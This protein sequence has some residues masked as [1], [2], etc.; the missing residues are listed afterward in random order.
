[1]APH[2]LQQL[3]EALTLAAASGPAA[4]IRAAGPDAPD[5]ASYEPANQLHVPDVS[6]QAGAVSSSPVE[7]HNS[8]QGVKEAARPAVPATSTQAE[9]VTSSPVKHPSSPQSFK[10]G[11]SPVSLMKGTSP[12]GAPTAGTADTTAEARATITD[13]AAAEAILGVPALADASLDS[14]QEEAGHAAEAHA[15]G[16]LQGRDNAITAAANSEAGPKASTE[17]KVAPNSSANVAAAASAVDQAASKP[18]AALTLPEVCSAALVW[19]ACL[20]DMYVT[21]SVDP[22]LVAIHVC[23]KP[24]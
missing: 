12:A 19:I 2:D 22:S 8:P 17:G 11:D 1:M 20:F 9:A 5:T 23:L 14:N 10:E 13:K 16:A 21:A 18:A 7:A 6:S 4:P 15:A 3:E 24:Y